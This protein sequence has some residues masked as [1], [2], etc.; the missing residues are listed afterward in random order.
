MNTHNW[1]KK[2]AIAFIVTLLTFVA[3]WSIQAA[4]N[5]LTYTYDGKQYMVGVST[6]VPDQA[7]QAYRVIPS[8]N[9]KNYRMGDR[10]TPYTYTGVDVAPHVTSV[11]TQVPVPKTTYVQKTEAVVQGTVKADEPIVLQAG[12]NMAYDTKEYQPTFSDVKVQERAIVN[13]A[14]AVQ[15]LSFPSV[16]VQGQ[17]T[18]KSQDE[19]YE[20]TQELNYEQ[21]VNHYNEVNRYYTHNYLHNLKQVHNHYYKVIDHHQNVHY[22]DEH[23]EQVYH[24]PVYET[25]LQEPLIQEPQYDENVQYE[26][27]G[28]R[29]Y[30]VPV[31]TVSYQPVVSTVVSP[32]M[33]QV[34][35]LAYQNYGYQN[36]GYQNYGYGG[37]GNYGY[38][39]NN[40]YNPVYPGGWYG[41][42]RY[43]SNWN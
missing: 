6:N 26:V 19:H 36:Y 42:W 37:Y 21:D 22:T 4:Q 2:I 17:D 1:T 16:Q 9:Y 14:P 34:T 33:P 11:V 25:D 41:N 43:A 15:D 7:A 13:T 20:D 3:A 35:P 39:G 38:G 5:P 31:T 18:T 28:E 23:V 40:R 12:Q 27:V 10:S 8:S 24:D 29:T 30:T 32:G